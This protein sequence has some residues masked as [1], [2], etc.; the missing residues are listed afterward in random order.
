MH[1][2]YANA[3]ERVLDREPGIAEMAAESILSDRRL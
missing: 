3:A 2:S 1:V